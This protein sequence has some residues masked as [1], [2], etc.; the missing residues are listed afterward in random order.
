MT[1]GKNYSGDQIVAKVRQV[2]CLIEQGKPLQEVCSSVQISRQTYDRWKGICDSIQSELESQ[3][4]QAA[5]QIDSFRKKNRQLKI[6]LKKVQDQISQYK[7][8][9]E[10]AD[11]RLSTVYDL[12]DQLRKADDARKSSD[13]IIE[14][15]KAKLS[16]T[17]EK[18]QQRTAA[19]EAV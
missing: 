12:Q 9:L 2:S 11:Q 19:K 14:Y 8:Q 5:K 6:K 10:V 17:E 7:R 15:L 16:K 3:T 1:M 4:K 13:I 18:L